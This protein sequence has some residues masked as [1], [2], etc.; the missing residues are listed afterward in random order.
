MFMLDESYQQSIK[1]NL[2]WPP[3]RSHEY[4]SLYLVIVA[5]CCGINTGLQICMSVKVLL[6]LKTFAFV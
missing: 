1:T 6:Q 4:C 3:L 5:F 2:S